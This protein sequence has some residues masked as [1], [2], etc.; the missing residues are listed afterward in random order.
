VFSLGVMTFKAPAVWCSDENSRFPLQGASKAPLAAA[1]LAEVDAGRLRMNETIRL[2]ALDLSPPPSRLN[3]AFAAKGGKGVLDVPA[4][5]LIALAVQENDNTAADAIMRRIGGPGA[6]TAWLRQHKIEDMRIDRYARE[7]QPAMSGMGSFRPTWTDEANWTAA[8][9][10]VAPATREAAMAAYLADPRD[11]TTTQAALN[12]LNQLSEGAL[13][14]AASTGLLSRLMNN[15][16]PGDSGLQAGLPSSAAFSHKSGASATDLGLTPATSDLGL[17]T[18]A[19]G[20]RFALAAFLAGSTATKA[21]REA[22][23]ADAARL[24][25]AALS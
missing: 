7:L 6:V 19:D 17:V 2:T 18:L 16:S 22:L 3:R 25:I 10:A 9:I 21:Q 12:F 20:R 4:A 11:T 24:S 15:P 5:D 13:L 1:A 23:F 14:S 8:R